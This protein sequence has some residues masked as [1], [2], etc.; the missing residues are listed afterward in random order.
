MNQQ[1]K[2]LDPP[3]GVIRMNKGGESP[4]IVSTNPKTDGQIS[5]S[6]I[7]WNET[8]NKIMQLLFEVGLDTVHV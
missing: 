7:Q 2:Y 5:F 8:T 1:H 3:A 4:C 6:K